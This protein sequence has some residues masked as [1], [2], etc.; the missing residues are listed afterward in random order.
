MTSTII[1]TFLDYAIAINLSP[2]LP[3]RM[4]LEKRVVARPE[5]AKQKG[6]QLGSPKIHDGILDKARALRREG[7][8]F[9][10]I[11][12]QLGVG[13]GTIRKKLNSKITD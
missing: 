5:N 4:R 8:S 6:K 3:V 13:E 9:R 12:K 11:E 7:L 1:L 10:K 2:V